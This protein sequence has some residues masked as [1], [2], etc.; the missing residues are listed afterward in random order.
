MIVIAA[1]SFFMSTGR[2]VF[3][4]RAPRSVH[5]ENKIA[6]VASRYL[7][8]LMQGRCADKQAVFTL[9]KTKLT[10]YEIVYNVRQSI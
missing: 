8:L 1:V 4:L 2:K 3:T 7:S 6:R 9:Y 5:S 10:V